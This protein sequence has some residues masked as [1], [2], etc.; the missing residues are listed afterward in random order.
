[1]SRPAACA[2]TSG[3]AAKCPLERAT[4]RSSAEQRKGP[5]LRLRHYRFPCEGAARRRRHSFCFRLKATARQRLPSRKA[6]AARERI[7]LYD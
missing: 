2:R 5:R 6:L 3:G 7:Q 1:M 4:L